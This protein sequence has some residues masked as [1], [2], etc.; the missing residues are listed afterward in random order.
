MQFPERDVYLMAGFSEHVF[1]IMSML[2]EDKDAMVK[3][4][5]AIVI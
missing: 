1:T 3:E 4:I 2:E 5:E